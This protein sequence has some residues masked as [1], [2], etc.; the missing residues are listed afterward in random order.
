MSKLFTALL[1]GMIS[2][3]IVDFFIFLGIWLNYIK[4]NEIEV[5]FNVLFADHQ[6][7]IIFLGSS[8]V[9]GF[10]FMYTESKKLTIFTILILTTLAILPLFEP[11]G[12]YV[13]EEMLMKKGV[14]YQDKRFSF[15]GDVYYDGREGITFYDHELKKMIILKKKDL[16]R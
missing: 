16:I 9:L 2:T 4:P 7:L 15:Y 8:V 11:V 1:V 14:T 6:N 5:F 12:K 13:G 3:F 10:I